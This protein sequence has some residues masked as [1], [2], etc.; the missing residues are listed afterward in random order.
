MRA[1]NNLR[2]KGT[3]LTLGEDERLAE[4]VRSYL[5]IYGKTC[6]EHKE[7]DRNVVEIVEMHGVRVRH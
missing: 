1:L 5:C 4:K 3:S 2:K 7:K 6:K